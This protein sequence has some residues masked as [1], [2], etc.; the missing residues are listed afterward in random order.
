[1]LV[2]NECTEFYTV[3]NDL[4]AERLRND[5]SPWP[6]E[7]SRAALGEGV[8]AWGTLDDAQKYLDRIQQRDPS[9]QILS[10]TIDNNDLNNLRSININALSDNDAAAFMNQYSRLFGGTPNHGYDYIQR[11]TNM[12]VEHYFSSIIFDLLNF[13]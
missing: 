11:G 7:P 1:M 5:G 12:G 4:D 6:N 2:H 13:G 9:A 10:F 8:Y 3:Q